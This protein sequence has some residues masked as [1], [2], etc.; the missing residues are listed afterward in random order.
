MHELGSEMET[1]HIR[2]TTELPP[3]GSQKYYEFNYQG[4]SAVAAS[5]EMLLPGSDALLSQCTYNSLSRDVVTHAGEDT[6]S[7]M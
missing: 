3:L 5:S 6:Q 7:E 1:R 2:N 4:G